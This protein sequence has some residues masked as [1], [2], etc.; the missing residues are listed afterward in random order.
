MLPD[1]TKLLSLSFALLLFAAGCTS[2]KS[3]EPEKSG[4]PAKANAPAN[5]IDPA[6]I[7]PANIDAANTDA[8]N[9]DAIKKVVG[10]TTKEVA[11]RE[12]KC[13]CSIEGIGHCGNYI[14]VEGQYVPLIHKS[15][16]KMEF[17]KQK[18]AGAKIKVAGM[19]K[20][21]KYVAEQWKMSQ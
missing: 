7:D 1:M 3:T 20:D 5:T 19:M 6:N 12:V 17:C 18:A 16:G 14:L 9:T 11:V 4:E 13:G 10:P 21:G 2:D 8:G 15:L